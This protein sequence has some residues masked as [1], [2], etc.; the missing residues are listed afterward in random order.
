M[1]HVPQLKFVGLLSSNIAPLFRNVR[2]LEIGSLDINGSVRTLFQACDYLGLDLA[3]GPGVDLVCEGQKY[4][5]PDG[6]FDVVISCEAMEHNPYWVDTF[7]NMI[8]LCRPGGLVVM[9]CA[10]T[11]RPEHGTERSSPEASP[12]TVHLGWNYYRNLRETDFASTI[13]LALYFERYRFWTNWNHY[14]LLFVGVRCGAVLSPE[15][16]DCWNHAIADIDSWIRKVNSGRVHRYR[17]T[18]AKWFGDRWFAFM[19]RIPEIFMWLHR[20]R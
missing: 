6:S 7:K 3:D 18:M 19:H 15:L 14:D 10:T 16:R 12:L 11:G 8:R 5:G 2:V 17:A 9:T 1:A 13:D 4:E 20:P